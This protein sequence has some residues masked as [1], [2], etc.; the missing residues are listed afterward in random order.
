[1]KTGTT[2]QRQQVMVLP[3]LAAAFGGPPNTTYSEV[4]GAVTL[5]RNFD[6][7]IATW[8][9]LPPSVSLVGK[10]GALMQTIPVLCHGRYYVCYSLTRVVGPSQPY[11]QSW[12]CLRPR[13]LSIVG[14]TLVFGIGGMAFGIGSVWPVSACAALSRLPWTYYYPRPNQSKHNESDVTPH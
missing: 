13:N 7:K 10:L 3:R 8:P 5:T 11:S 1:M 2:P 6:P 14:V 9:P 4:T 12:I